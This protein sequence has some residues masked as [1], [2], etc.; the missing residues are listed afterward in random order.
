MKTIWVLMVLLGQNHDLPKEVNSH[1]VLVILM[2]DEATCK[3][4]K[5]VNSN[6]GTGFTCVQVD[7]D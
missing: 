3:Q 2:P 1:Q 4:V 7:P 6:G 5:H